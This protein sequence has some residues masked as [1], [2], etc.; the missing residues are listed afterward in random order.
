[1]EAT[2]ETTDSIA[3]ANG[4]PQNAP[5]EHSPDYYNYG[6]I[7]FQGN[8]PQNQ[9]QND[10]PLENQIS[11]NSMESINDQSF[12]ENNKTDLDL[13][14]E[15]YQREIEEK[16]RRMRSTQAPVQPQAYQTPPM[17]QQMPQQNYQQPMQQ[18]QPPPYQQQQPVYQQPPIQQQPTRQHQQQFPQSGEDDSYEVYNMELPAYPEQD[19]PPTQRQPIISSDG[20]DDSMYFTSVDT[21]RQKRPVRKP[22]NPK[23]KQPQKGFLSKLFNK[24]EP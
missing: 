14:I 2:F 9:I 3:N 17:Q 22:V 16:Q 5:A 4:Y 6:N 15:K 10:V 13:E 18:M 1:L 7:S 24:D 19:M 8:H 23:N 20:D 21:D 11:Y 12:E